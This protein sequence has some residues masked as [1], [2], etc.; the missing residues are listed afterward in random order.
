MSSGRKTEDTISNILSTKHYS[1]FEHYNRVLQIR[2]SER[3]GSPEMLRLATILANRKG[4]HC[5]WDV[6]ET[7]ER[8]DGPGT[9]RIC[10]DI[11]AILE[12]D[13]VSARLGL[14][15]D[16]FASMLGSVLSDVWHEEVPLLLPVAQS[17]S[18]LCAQAL[19]IEDYE[20][21]APST[22]T[23]RGSAST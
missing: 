22:T 7:P 5:H 2:F 20:F 8:P 3:A 23:R 12:W 11:R 18:R 4:I 1:V 19:G 9:L 21:V 10:S 17:D 14:G 16:K 13:L 6:F 15:E